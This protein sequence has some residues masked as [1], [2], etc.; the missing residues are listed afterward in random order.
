MAMN[1]TIERQ[2]REPGVKGTTEILT[3]DHQG[4]KDARR[5]SVSLARDVLSSINQQVQHLN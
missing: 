5:A 4:H 1:Q 3:E 2:L